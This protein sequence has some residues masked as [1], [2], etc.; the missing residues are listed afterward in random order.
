MLATSMLDE[1]V[2][3]EDEFVEETATSAFP[4]VLI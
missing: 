3:T 4:R 1:V 2:A